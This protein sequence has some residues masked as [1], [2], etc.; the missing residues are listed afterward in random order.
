MKPV[1]NFS[2]PVRNRNS[3]RNFTRNEKE[4]RVRMNRRGDTDGG[5]CGRGGGVKTITLIRGEI[6]Y[7]R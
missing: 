2:S 4:E 3:T 5:D 6:K 7:G 1:K